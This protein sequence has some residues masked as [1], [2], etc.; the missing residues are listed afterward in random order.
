MKSRFFKSSVLTLGT[1]AIIALSINVASSA[2]GK[3]FKLGVQV[4]DG[5]Y[6]ATQKGA[7]KYTGTSNITTSGLIPSLWAT[8]TNGYDPD[9]MNLD[10]QPATTELK[11]DFRMC[12][13]FA[14]SVALYADGSI[15][16]LSQVG[17]MQCTPWASEGG[18]W[19]KA[20]T[21]SNGYDW[22]AAQ[23][24]IETRPLPAG[25]VAVSD[26]R[27]G[28]RLC[29]KACTSQFGTTQYT[30]WASAGGGKSAWFSDGNWYDSDGG[31]LILEVAEA[32]IGCTE[33]VPA[34]QQPKVIQTAQ[35]VIGIDG[36]GTG[37][38]NCSSDSILT[39]LRLHNKTNDRK[40]WSGTCT[41][42]ENL[43]DPNSSIVVQGTT[44]VAPRYVYPTADDAY[45]ATDEA[46]VGALYYDDDA[47]GSSDEG[48]RAISCRKLVAGVSLD[49]NSVQV[50]PNAGCGANEC[51]S[52]NPTYGA[53]GTAKDAQGRPFVPIG[54]NIRPNDSHKYARGIWAAPLK[55]L[56]PQTIECPTTQPPTQDPPT[57]VGGIRVH[58]F[59]RNTDGTPGQPVTGTTAGISKT[60][61]IADQPAVFLQL[62]PGS[63]P[64]FVTDLPGE[65]KFSICQFNIGGSGCAG[66]T[67]ATVPAASCTAGVCA[68]PM[69]GVT[70]GK[71]TALIVTYAPS[72]TV[73]PIPNPNP[74]PNPNPPGPTCELTATPSTIVVNVGS[75]K[76]EWTCTNGSSAQITDDNAGFTDIGNKPLTGSVTVSPDKTTTFT[77]TAGGA[78]A[79]ATVVVGGS[80][81]DE[82]GGL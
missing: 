11:S 33:A 24:A 76:L 64:V 5:S 20:A 68:L 7:Y 70:A 48:I 37:W 66:T 81:I 22:D 25:K 26:Y 73:T 1:L 27:I 50:F 4:A 43:V 40:E 79:S 29:D 54:M 61:M 35:T 49:L 41:D 51:N 2:A 34:D 53:L 77:V 46:L 32:L 16:T 56:P 8:D 78:S 6:C 15:R 18:G 23:V 13:Q 44:I 17:T 10:L 31:Q 63:Y 38:K 82:T 72:T 71:M 30:P 75:S 57:S 52:Y 21:D 45:C 69:T 74:N 67:F 42:T 14:D 62:T 80:T 47:S 28:G 58:R 12:I 60:G 59:T 36:T 19:S 65:E 55:S 39:N 3:D 9:C